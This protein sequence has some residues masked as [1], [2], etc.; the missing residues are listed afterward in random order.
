MK[1]RKR[2]KDARKQSNIAYQN[3]DILSK[4]AAEYFKGKSLSAYGIGLPRIA[5][6]LPTNLPAIEANELRID[7]FFRFEDGSCGI[8]DYESVYKDI[9]QKIKYLNYVARIAGRFHRDGIPLRNLRFIV[10]YTADVERREVSASY[11]IGCLHFEV[12]PAFLSEL[13]AD[14]IFPKIKAKI[15]AGERLGEE[16]QMQFIVLPLAK[17]GKEEKARLL[18]EEIELGKQIKDEEQ[19][20]FLLSAM[21]VFSDKIVDED[22]AGKVRRWIGMTKV[23]RIFEEEK[24]AAIKKVE[25]EKEEEKARALR[26]QEQEKEKEKAHALRKKEKE[27]VRAL[28]EKEKEKARE[29]REKEKEKAMMSKTIVMNLMRVMKMSDEDILKTV[30]I[31]SPAEIRSI[32][33]ELDAAACG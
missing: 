31:Y 11:D 3:K 6:V 18:Q 14:G 8:V 26:K 29:L 4:L 28:R 1:K 16:E 22:T 30:D 13:D 20:V 24:L 23:G 2:K 5:E 21:L 33:E 19:G 27:K 15:L 12:E 17:K 25:Q 10:I 32:R 9:A 7:N